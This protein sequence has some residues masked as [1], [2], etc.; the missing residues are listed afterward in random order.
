MINSY[1]KD[2]YNGTIEK[3]KYLSELK[4]YG[5]SIFMTFYGF[6]TYKKVG[7][8]LIVGDIYIHGKYRKTGL[9]RKLFDIIRARA[10]ETGVNILIGFSEKAGVNHIDGVKSLKAVG[11]I[12]TQELKDTTVFMR[13]AY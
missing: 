12:P 8:A 2:R 11:F 3:K 6:F 1:L 4:Q 10:K 7:D 9:S 5:F 13:G